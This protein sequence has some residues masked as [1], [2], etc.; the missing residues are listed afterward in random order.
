MPRRLRVTCLAP[1]ACGLLTNAIELKR[2]PASG[3]EPNQQN[4]RGFTIPRPVRIASVTHVGK[5]IIVDPTDTTEG[6]T[7]ELLGATTVVEYRNPPKD[8]TRCARRPKQ[9]AFLRSRRPRA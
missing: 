4:M 8:S 2:L 7:A 9:S 1:D 5:E 3:E 6:L